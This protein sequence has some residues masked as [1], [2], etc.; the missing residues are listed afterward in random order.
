MKA[1]NLLPADRRSTNTSAGLDPGRRNLLIVC[2][3]VGVLL[4][5]GLA[6]MVWSSGSSLSKKRSELA[7]I[8]ARIASTSSATSV[9]AGAGAGTRKSTVIG[10]VA[11]R[12]SWDQF[13]GTLS[14]VMPEDVWLQSLQSTT[15]G[16][17]ATLATNQAAL[18]AASAPAATTA[19]TTTPAPAPAAATPSTFT[20][21]GYTY[22]QPSVARMMRRLNLVPWLTGVTLV[23]ST[24]RLRRCGHRLPVL[25]QGQ[26][27]LSG[28]N[29]MS[30]RITTISP[31]KL[32]AILAGTFVL[33]AA[34]MWI[35][36]VLPKQSKA[37]SLE[38]TIAS[39]KTQL[40]QLSVKQTAVQK[41]AVSQSLLL[42]RA[43]PTDV[44]IP[45]IVLQLSRIATE[46]HVSLDSITPSTPVSYSGYQSVPMTLS[47]T[48]HS[49]DIQNFLAQLRNQVKV[50]GGNVAATGRLYDVL[51]VTLQATTP[52]P[53]VSA[54]VT[55]DAFNYTGITPTPP[56]A[57]PGAAPTTSST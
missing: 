43:L 56:G 34:G 15:A 19:T 16:A 41:Q 12:L 54:T 29:P 57:V 44:G 55:V 18:A 22:S 37:K 38:T 4:I 7:S 9:A 24:K 20:I 1:V 3:V 25:G 50:S 45:Q 42:A 33:L 52:A 30:S 32:V 26:R 51:G 47:V 36:L 5:A 14:K 53:D 27:R 35:T 23:S 46:E 39:A 49:L 11:N 40:T 48:G 21:S 13:L 17:A 6:M 28:G 31:V 10:L 8:Q 2:A